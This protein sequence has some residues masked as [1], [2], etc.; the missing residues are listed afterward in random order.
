MTRL[1]LVSQM[2]WSMWD[3]QVW[4]RFG[5]DARWL[6][7]KAKCN[8]C[9]SVHKLTAIYSCHRSG[10]WWWLIYYNY[11]PPP[12]DLIDLDET[13]VNA[14]FRCRRLKLN[15]CMWVHD[16]SNGWTHSI[17]SM[18]LVQKSAKAILK[19]HIYDSYQRILCDHF[20][21]YCELLHVICHIQ[22]SICLMIE[23]YLG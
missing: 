17:V 13:S 6:L 18:K 14:F 1:V 19:V 12:N 15:I 2:S 5:D 16:L 20:S 7:W 3:V 8:L 11:A 22:P 10:T 9:R 23:V 21:F 4:Y